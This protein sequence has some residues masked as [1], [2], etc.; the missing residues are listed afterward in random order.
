MATA[1]LNDGLYA[2]CLSVTDAALAES[3]SDLGIRNLKGVCLMELGRLKEAEPILL[4]ICKE[5]NTPECWNNLASL[6]QRMKNFPK[7]METSSKALEF[8]S[9]TNPENALSNRALCLLDAHKNIEAQ[10][11]AEQAKAKNASSC[12]VRIVLIK[13][14]LRRGATDEAI[15][16]SSVTLSLCP[17]E[18]RA[19]FWR[20]YVLFKNGQK[21]DAYKIYRYI[22]EQFR[23]GEI[24]EASKSNIELL[25]NRIPIPE[26]TL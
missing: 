6:Y 12:A 14:M 10:A 15:Q 8:Y 2:E 7:C 20:A 26:P 3:P 13:S 22:V 11:A 23:R 17:A 21:N 1:F 9:Y 18:P 4:G 25:E 5:S 16:E 24:V 19:H